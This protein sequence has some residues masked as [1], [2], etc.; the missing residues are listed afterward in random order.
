MTS[1]Q[2]FL[3]CLRVEP[4]PGFCIRADRYYPEGDLACSVA[5][6]RGGEKRICDRE[7]RTEAPLEPHAVS[8]AVKRE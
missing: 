7:S 8:L 6:Q 5:N 1:N 3:R 4:A 2:K